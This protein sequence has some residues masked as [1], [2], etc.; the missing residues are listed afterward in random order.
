MLQFPLH[1]Y[2]G[3]SPLIPAMK[4]PGFD[5]SEMST[6]VAAYWRR[7]EAALLGTS[8][9]FNAGGQTRTDNDSDV[10]WNRVQEQLKVEILAEK[11]KARSR[12][13]K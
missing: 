8:G 4:L 11:K 3:G 5:V 6:R 10:I 9:Y 12:E 7:R 1:S 2:E 13:A